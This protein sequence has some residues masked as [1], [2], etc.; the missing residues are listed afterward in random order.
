MLRKRHPTRLRFAPAK[1]SPKKPGAPDRTL[2]E[3]MSAKDLA[4]GA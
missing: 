2:L 1:K 3:V 4:V